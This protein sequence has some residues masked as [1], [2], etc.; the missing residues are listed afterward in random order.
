VI[1]AVVQIHGAQ[2]TYFATFGNGNFGSLADLE[3]ANFI[4]AALATGI[5]YG[6]T[7][8]MSVTPG[9]PGTPASFVLTA[10][11]QRYPKTGRRS[12]FIDIS[13]ELR[14][15]DKNGG[16]ATASD[17]Y[18]D[19]C[20]LW[21]MADNERCTIQDLRTLHGAQMT[22][23]ATY[24]SGNFGNFTQLRDAL[25]ISR[26]LAMGSNHGYYFV[27]IIYHQIL[28]NVPASF[29]IYS[30]PQSYGTTG[31]RSF[32]IDTSGVLRGADKNGVLAD[33]N[34]PPINQ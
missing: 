8:A 2:M 7:F 20:A 28:P 6:Y 9:S 11:P 12:F 21:G 4:D 22:Y 3:Q 32:F 27:M 16:V 34:D 17:P 1:Q 30:A 23:A 29:K 14:G 25:L 13:G 10:T 31:V 33:E 15:G 5:K 18:I 24:G 19:S 26:T